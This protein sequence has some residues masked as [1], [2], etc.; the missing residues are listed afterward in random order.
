MTFIK[1]APAIIVV[2]LMLLMVTFSSCSKEED[3]PAAPPTTATTGAINLSF[4][5]REQ[6]FGIYVPKVWNLTVKILQGGGALETRN[7]TSSNSTFGNLAPGTY[8][9]EVTGNITLGNDGGQFA[10]QTVNIY[11]VTNEA[12]QVTAGN[13]TQKNITVEFN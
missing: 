13:T 4:Q 3:P 2:V 5:A 8:Q 6:G 1:K 10:N 12:A 7:V 9:I 11:P